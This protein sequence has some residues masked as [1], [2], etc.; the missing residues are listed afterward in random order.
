MLTGLISQLTTLI[1]RI[2]KPISSLMAPSLTL[3][4]PISSLMA[5]SLT[6]M[7]PIS[8]LM[9]PSLTLETISIALIWPISVAG[10]FTKE[11]RMAKRQRTVKPL[12]TIW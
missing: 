3:L 5:P 4:A 11:P 10:A 6:L 2:M 9:A 12:A 8:S 7:A 1:L